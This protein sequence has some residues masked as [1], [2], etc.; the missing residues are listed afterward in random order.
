MPYLGGTAPF[1]G[2]QKP[3]PLLLLTVSDLNTPGIAARD[4]GAAWEVLKG[5]RDKAGERD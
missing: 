2:A 1:P 5:P 4:G 3:D